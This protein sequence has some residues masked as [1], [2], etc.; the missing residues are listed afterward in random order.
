V[1]TAFRL[2]NRRLEQIQLAE[3]DELSA[4]AV[5]VDI[6]EPTEEERNSISQ[7]YGVRL[8]DSDDMQEIE[9]T[10]R[11]F[12]DEDGL[13]I[14]SFFLDDFAETPTTVPVACHTPLRVR[15]WNRAELYRSAGKD[16]YAA[17][18]PSRC[19]VDELRHR[20]PD[21]LARAR[22]HGVP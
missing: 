7:V 12:K 2:Q 11:F 22:R 21:P 6:V 3:T 19:F 17:L 9:A 15:G 18:P 20:R 8:P 14:H 16:G 10:A 5:W 13:H 1:L 4:D